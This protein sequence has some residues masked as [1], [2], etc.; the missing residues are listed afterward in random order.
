MAS[1]DGPPPPGAAASPAPVLAYQNRIKHRNEFWDKC[2]ADA[3]YV[4]EVLAKRNFDYNIQKF[5]NNA[6]NLNFVYEG[7]IW[8]AHGRPFANES[9]LQKWMCSKVWSHSYRCKAML[10]TTVEVDAVIIESKFMEHNHEPDPEGKTVG[11][12]YNN[13][14]LPI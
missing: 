11:I 2:D 6:G 5:E 1:I 10:A 14:P 7:E 13:S 3:D 12:Y 9:L 8:Q 4:E